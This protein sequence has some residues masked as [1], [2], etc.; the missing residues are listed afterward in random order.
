MTLTREGFEVIT[1][2][3][4]LEALELLAENM[5]DIILS[6]VNMPKL[7]GYK[8]CRFVRKHDRTKDIPVVM[9]SGKDGVFDKLR[10]KMYG[11]EDYITKPFE[12]ADLID[13]VRRYTKTYAN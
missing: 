5:P 7:D 2:G 13:K 11:C 10:G 9:L 4:G 3:D 12:S 8:L 1:A 6:D